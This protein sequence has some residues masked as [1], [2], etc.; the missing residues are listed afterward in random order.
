MFCPDHV[1]RN[2]AQLSFFTAVMVH[3]THNNTNTN[4][5]LFKTKKPCIRCVAVTVNLAQGLVPCPSPLHPAAPWYQAVTY[6][7]VFSFA[8]VSI[9]RLARN[10]V[11]FLF[12][13]CVDFEVFL[14]HSNLHYHIPVYVCF[15]L[16]D[17]ICTSKMFPEKRTYYPIL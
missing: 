5:I 2:L 3:L 8:C 16:T 11:C 1:S 4:P 15:W 13:M 14:I 10:W 7:C 12:F 9:W 6:L 17:N